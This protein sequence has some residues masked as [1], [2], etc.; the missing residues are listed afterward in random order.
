[1]LHGQRIGELEAPS[2]TQRGLGLAEGKA[3]LRDVDGG[4]ADSQASRTVLLLG[5]KRAG[6][7][8]KVRKA[9]IIDQRRTKDTGEPEKALVRPI[10]I[11]KP[12]RWIS[13]RLGVTRRE[14][15]VPIMRVANKCRVC[16]GE[17]RI[18][19]QAEQIAERRAGGDATE[20]SEITY[21]CSTAMLRCSLRSQLAKKKILLRRIGPPSAKPNCRRSK[22]GSGLA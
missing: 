8:E 12:V 22:N 17:P 18:Q 20:G 13:I 16:L 19:A 11:A 15:P 4:C 2:K 21:E 3:G 6:T 9:K 14:A 10:Q 7:S 5:R 1:M